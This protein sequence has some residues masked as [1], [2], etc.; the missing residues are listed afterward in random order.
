MNPLRVGIW[1]CGSIASRH[2]EAIAA[3]PDEMRLAACASR[4]AAS[5]QA[6]AIKFGAT[7][8]R[9]F[10]SLLRSAELELLIIAIPP[11]AH[12]GEVEKAAALGIH[13]L[14]EKPIA[15]TLERATSMVNAAAEAKIVAACGFM[16]RFGDAVLR[17]DRAAAAGE[18]GRV[19][20]FIGQFH[21]NAL[22]SAWWREQGRSGGQMVEQLIHIVDLARHQ[23]GMPQSVYARA[24]NFFHAGV[25]RYDSDDASALI[26]GFEDGR[27]GVLN[28]TN[29]AVPGK[30][31]KHWQLVAERMTAR[32]TGWNSGVF[33][34]TGAEPRIEHID[35]QT[36]VFIAQL[37][38][39]SGAIRE[40]RAPRVPLTDGEQ[41][42]RI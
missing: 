13:L 14:V 39:V 40:R 17:W 5:A 34:H 27:I 11:F 6:F 37:R 41:S 22:H 25:E 23:L 15:L 7:A 10:D 33:T 1:G 12:N 20:M 18:T 16:Y 26:L 4:D 8:Y 32:F 9:D 30:W 35:T 38:D 2:A 36:D 24:S 19:G 21:S 28:A 42:L 31:D 3:I 29:G